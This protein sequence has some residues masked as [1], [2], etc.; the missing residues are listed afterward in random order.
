MN[1]MNHFPTTHTIAARGRL[2]LVAA[3]LAVALLGAACTTVV[4]APAPP[5]VVYRE[6]P[7]PVV[8]VI[9]AAPAPGFN[10]VPGHWV[11]RNNGWFWQTGR[12][13]Q[14]A[15]PPM[16]PIISETITIAPS[17][18]HFWVRGHWAWR[19]GNWGWVSGRWVAG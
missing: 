9:P 4:R 5:R 12:Y 3:G 8:E 17:P 2:R 6:M 11:W 1:I 7:A 10:W 18:A 14:S 13:V 19:G 15:V 16:P